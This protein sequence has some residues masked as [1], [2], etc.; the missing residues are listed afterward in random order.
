MDVFNMKQ[1]AFIK[2]TYPQR[3]ANSE[4]ILF[5]YV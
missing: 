4:F 5:I 1:T 2:T 3:N